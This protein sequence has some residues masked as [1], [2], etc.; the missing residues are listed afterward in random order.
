MT[1]QTLISHSSL[2]LRIIT[3]Y[4][5]SYDIKHA[6]Q[7]YKNKIYLAPYGQ[8]LYHVVI[9]SSESGVLIKKFSTIGHFCLIFG[10]KVK[11]SADQNDKYRLQPF[12]EYQA[13]ADNAQRF[14][15]F[16]GEVPSSI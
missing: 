16:F 8:I 10:Q 3:H 14:R 15:K 1:H 9:K 5:E 11:Y 13:P 6:I 2:Q 4:N 12:L 7:I